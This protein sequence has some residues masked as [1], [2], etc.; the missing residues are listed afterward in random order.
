[1]ISLR[2]TTLVFL[3]LVASAFGVGLGSWG[4]GAVDSA[5]SPG[6]RSPRS[7]RQ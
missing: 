3:V 2:R 1:M 4:A 5:K 6:A 7:R